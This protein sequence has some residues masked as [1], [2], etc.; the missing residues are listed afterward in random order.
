MSV[1]FEQLGLSPGLVAAL[2]AEN[3]TVPMPIQALV[4]PE[5][6][7]NLDLLVQSQTGTGKT[8]AFL[9]PLFEK[10]QPVREMQALLLVPT[11]ELAVQ[12][13]RQIEKL[14]E[15]SGKKLF[16]VSVIGKVNIE[17]QIEK[18]RDKP[19][20]IV[21]TPGRVLELI[22][23]KKI[24]AHTLKTIVIDEADRLLDA[25]NIESIRAVI[26]TTQRDRQILLV[27]ATIS[28]ATR[29]VAEKIMKSPQ[30]LRAEATAKL[31]VT[32]EHLYVIAELRDKLETLRKL[33]NGTQPAKA[34]VFINTPYQIDKALENLNYHGLSAESLHGDD[35]KTDRKATLEKFRAGKL[36]IL[37]A[38]DIAAR[39][40]DIPDVTHVFN[41]DLPE[42]PDA[43]LHR[44]GRTGRT[45]K[46][47]VVVS[48]ITD[49]EL[50]LMHKHAKALGL[51][52]KEKLLF[53]GNLV[54][55]MK[56]KDLLT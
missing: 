1:S 38:S 50:P 2:A 18:L 37:I 4:I 25:D 20:L 6:I 48:L 56:S 52:I 9:L 54:D 26:K 45:G 34:L 49:S 3:I 27:S 30:L 16:G 53:K 41:V 21:G 17:R 10:L 5:A 39:G 24:S 42:S 55:P 32:I 15:N 28:P 23:K 22:A 13:L 40:L 46:A 14:S 8:L 43:Y 11:H 51:V 36:R 47:G 31:P 35:K 33:I 7:K 29:Q 12:I 44:A 19:Q